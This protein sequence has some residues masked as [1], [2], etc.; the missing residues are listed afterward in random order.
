MK[1]A[2]L[3]ERVYSFCEAH[4][5]DGKKSIVKHFL[6]E[7]TPKRTIYRMIKRWEDG[8]PPCRTKESGRKPEIMTS[9]NIRRLKDSVNNRSGISTRKLAKKFNCTQPYIVQT[10]KK[11]TDIR[12]KKKFWFLIELKTRN[13]G[14]DLA[15]VECWQ[16]FV[17]TNSFWTMSRILRFHIRLKILTL[18]T[19]YT[20]DINSTSNNVKFKIKQKFEKKLLVWVAI[21]P[22]G[23]SSSFIAPSGLAID[24]HVYLN[25]CIVKRLIPFINK[26][27]S[28]NNYVF[29]PDLAS[30]HYAKSVIAHLKEKNVIFVEKE[31]NPPCVPELRPIKNLWSILKGLVYEKGWEAK[32]YDDLKNRVKYCLKKVD[33]TLVHQMVSSVNSK[34]DR[35]RRHG[36]E[37]LY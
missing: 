19:T 15:A 7:N 8:L 11:K 1:P 6:D 26:Y 28:D 20:N 17:I 35:V 27:H 32:T 3:I 2:S 16:N 24:Q 30:S 5:N 12:Y 29:W 31:D 34:V 33:M 4:W 13:R 18:V 22:R 25:E 21:S 36:I 9:K 14:F 37:C 10:L 23:I